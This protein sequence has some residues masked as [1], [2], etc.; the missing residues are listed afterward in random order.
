MPKKKD[1]LNIPGMNLD[2]KYSSKKSV[3]PETSGKAQKDM[4]KTKQ[5]LEKLKAFILKKYKFLP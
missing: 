2:T 1:D 3:I 4:E 5:E